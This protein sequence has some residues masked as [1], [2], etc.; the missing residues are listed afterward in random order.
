MKDAYNIVLAISPVGPED[1][2]T[3]ACDSANVGLRR[4]T[5]EQATEALFLMKQCRVYCVSDDE[6]AVHLMTELPPFV[7][8]ALIRKHA[9]Y[10][11]PYPTEALLT[12]FLGQ[13]E[14]EG[15]LLAA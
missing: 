14:Y 13:L 1:I 3:A 5:F 12:E 2:A 6:R 7:I 8:R 9:A 15:V 4:C 10:G 11:R